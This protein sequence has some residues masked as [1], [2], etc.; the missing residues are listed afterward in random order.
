MP[1]GKD[2]PRSSCPIACSLD[3]LGDRWTLVVLRDVL[4][5]Q[6]RV[7]SEIAVD[8]GIATNTLT[9]R[10]DRLIA[11]GVLERRQDPKDGRS[12]KYIPTQCGLEL[13]PV[14]VDLMVWGMKYTSGTR[15]EETLVRAVSD[16][17]AFLAELIERARETDG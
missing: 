3:L 12:R 13:I 10:L 16:R 2:T 8:E 9:N 11:A 14:L 4:L 7:F 17:E 5:R 15:S 1:F 6:R